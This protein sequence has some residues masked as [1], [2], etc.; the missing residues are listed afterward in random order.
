MNEENLEVSRR[1]FKHACAFLDCASFCQIE[2]NNIE[3][4][5]HSHT[6]AGIVNSAFACEVFIKSLL[7]YHGEPISKMKKHKLK[8]L[9]E[10]YRSKDEAKALFVEREMIAWFNSNN[11]NMFHELL[12]ICS[13]AFEEWRYIYEKEE[14]TVNVLFL[15]DLALMLRGV[16]CQDFY[17]MSWEEF[18]REGN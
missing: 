4:R 7:V 1:M 2:P 9:W 6:V 18:K 16:C 10:N 14:E 8:E 5:M 15:R 11:E 12:D 13:N 17:G 3:Y